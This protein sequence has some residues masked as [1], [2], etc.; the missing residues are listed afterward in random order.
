MLKARTILIFTSWMK[1]LAAVKC[2]SEATG[3]AII[4]VLQG[5]KAGR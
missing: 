1:S 5:F 3:L 4:N 2:I